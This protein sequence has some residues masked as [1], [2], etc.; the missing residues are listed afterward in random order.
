MMTYDFSQLPV[1]QH[2]KRDLKGVISWQSIGQKLAVGKVDSKVRNLMD[3]NYQLIS[4]E[5]SLF[6]ALPGIIEHDYV[7]IQNREKEICGIVTA[8]DLSLQF[9]QL[10]EPFLLVAEIENHVRQI[11]MKLSK[12]E[13]ANGKDERD[14]NR[15]VDTVADL[16]FGE[17]LR[18]CQNQEI[19]NKLGLSIDRKAFCTLLDSVRDIRNN[20]MHFDPDGLE[21]SSTETLRSFVRLLQKLRSLNVF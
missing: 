12:E 20:I 2:A 19:W 15:K 14:V 7:L 3:T 16:N 11:L 6:K 18:L 8:S 10:T 1:M 5:T 13:L 9:K 17:Y 4:S 21:Q